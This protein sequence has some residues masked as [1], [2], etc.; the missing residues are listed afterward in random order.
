MQYKISIV[1]ICFNSEK[2]ILTTLQSIVDQDYNNYEIVIKDG[3]SKDNTMR[4][5]NSFIDENPNTAFIIDSSSDKGIYNAMNV[6]IDMARGEWIFFLNSGDCFASKDV[7]SKVSKTLIDENDVVFG[8]VIMCDGTGDSR[9]KG[10]LSQI[11]KKM[12]FGHQSCFIKTELSRRYK[13]NEQYKIAADYDMILRAYKEGRVFEYLD[14]DIARFDMDGISSTGFCATMR[15]RYAVRCSNKV[16]EADYTKTF[17]YK[18]DIL[19]ARIKEY[20]LKH[21]SGKILFRLREFYKIKI[22]KYQKV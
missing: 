1:T 10:D 3:L 22:K 6:A 5:V 8:N 19:L 15:E 17:L 4:I 14:E 7:L 2:E 11:E 9:W 12:P 20:I 18:K 16:I 21:F 13:F